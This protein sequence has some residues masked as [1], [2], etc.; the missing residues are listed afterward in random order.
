VG[1]ALLIIAFVIETAL[2]AY[3]IATKENHTRLRAIIRVGVLPV[4]VCA[5][6][7]TVTEGSDIVAAGSSVDRLPEFL[8]GSV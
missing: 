2:A 3:C 6:A 7:R 4:P 8:R 1:T 5:H